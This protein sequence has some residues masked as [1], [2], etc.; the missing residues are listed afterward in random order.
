MEVWI[1][2]SYYYLSSSMN[3]CLT[4]CQ[5]T[6]GTVIG[7]KS[8]I[9]ITC[10]SSVVSINW[11]SMEFCS[12]KHHYGPNGGLTP[13][14]NVFLSAATQVTEQIKLVIMGISLALYPHPPCR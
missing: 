3:Q 9:A 4:L 5:A 13:S 1:R 11:D 8:F 6:C 7:V 12:Q 10:A 14:P 2:P